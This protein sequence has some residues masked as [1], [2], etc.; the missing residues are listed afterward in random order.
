MLLATIPKYDDEGK[1]EKN[2]KGIKAEGV[3]ELAHLLDL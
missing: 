1:P 3:D 2:K